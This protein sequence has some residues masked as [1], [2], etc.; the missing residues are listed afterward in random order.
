MKCKQ[1]NL[2]RIP[3]KTHLLT[4]VAYR[5]KPHHTKNLYLRARLDTCVDVNN[6]PASVYRLV[7]QDPEMKKLA[8]SKC[9]VRQCR[10]SFYILISQGVIELNIYL[11]LFCTKPTQFLLIFRFM[12]FA[13]LGSI[14]FIVHYL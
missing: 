10:T 9:C 11:F 6:L 14:I 1:V 2:Q 3:R 5:L 8:S 13:H 7:F 12:F 4:N